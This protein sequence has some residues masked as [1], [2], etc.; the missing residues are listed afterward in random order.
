[1]TAESVFD[2]RMRHGD[3]T[4]SR[5]LTGARLEIE[6]R[7]RMLPA[8][9]TFTHD[10]LGAGWATGELGSDGLHDPARGPV[11]VW[12]LEIGLSGTDPDAALRLALTGLLPEA[13][14]DELIVLAGSLASDPMPWH[15]EWVPEVPPCLAAQGAAWFDVLVPSVN[16]RK[17]DCTAEPV[18]HHR[19]ARLVWAPTWCVTIW[20]AQHGGADSEYRTWGLPQRTY[21]G[22]DLVRLD[23]AAAMA[24]MLRA[25]VNHIEWSVGMVDV[26]LEAWENHF[27]DQ[28]ATAGGL[29]VGPDLDRL[30]RHLAALGGGIALNRDAIRTLVR[31]SQVQPGFPT[32]IRT[33]VDGLCERLMGQSQTQRRAVRESFDL[34]ASATAGQQ[35]RLAQ[36]RADRDGAFQA[37]V[38]ILAA[39]FVAPGLIAA[40]YGANVKGLP[41]TDAVTG[42]WFMLLGSVT[43]SVLSIGLIFVV[44]AWSRRRREA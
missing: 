30:Q 37:V 42:L 38:G 27:L 6:R 41:G 22:G 11:Q 23:G 24:E 33:H 18:I 32:G 29:F 21:P 9:D 20:S 4:E 28:A 2:L 14:V 35:F 44:R 1:M 12:D 34:V 43:A 10:V 7:N 8:E 36:E 17:G 15:A 5:V 26:E 3:G 39:V 25:V 31:R 16:W 19:N 40:F 13:C